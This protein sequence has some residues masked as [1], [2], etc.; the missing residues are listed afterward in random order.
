MNH[1]M[2]ALAIPVFFLLIGVELWADLRR[3]RGL[4]RLNDAVTDLS[5][6]VSQQALAVFLNVGIVAAYQFVWERAAI[7]PFAPTDPIAWVIAFFGVDFLYYWWHRLSHEVNVL[8]AVHVVHHHSQDYNLAVALRQ[9]LFSSATS[10]PFYLPLAVV[11]LPPTVTFPMFGISTLY[12]FWIH[13]RTIDRVRFMEGWLNT[14]SAHRVHHGINPI[15]ID[16]NHGAIF[17]IWDRLFG[18]WQPETEEVVYG[19]VTPQESWNPLWANVEYWAKV[20]KLSARATRFIDK[21]QV[22]L[23]PPGWMPRNL[24]PHEV[25]PPVDARTFVKFDRAFPRAIGWYVVAQYLP[26]VVGTF[27]VLW[28]A[29]EL[30][31]AAMAAIVALLCASTFTF[32]ALFEGRSYAPL[33]ESVRLCAC[34][35]AAVYF[36]GV[37][38]G[39][40][41]LASL[42]VAACAVSIIGLAV[43]RT[44]GRAS[45]VSHARF[46]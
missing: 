30:D 22:W 41:F 45:R 3:R 14:P 5:C 36:V 42:A 8:W 46:G 17:V 18:T 11:G 15:Y 37:R 35:A 29:A 20:A 1:Q 31:T 21:V 26:V 43:A 38:A 40:G 44:R 10:L 9:A 4:Y 33:V 28:F 32:G 34:A 16:R 23:R 19:T 2:I 7:A 12:Q 27:C 24:E 39:E 6:G 13:T 25:A